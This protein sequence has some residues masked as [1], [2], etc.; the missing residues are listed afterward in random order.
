MDIKILSNV[1][2]KL[3]N[4]KEISFQ[5]I[6]S[7]KTPSKEELKVILCKTLNLSPSTTVIVNVSQV[8]GVM[9]SSVLAHSYAHEKDMV[10]E[11]KHFAK[12]AEKKAGKGEEKKEPE[13]KKEEKKEEAKHEKEEKKE[14]HHEKKEENKEPEKKE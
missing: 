5:V 6:Y 1:D 4:R 2:N 12:R 13:A 8:F 3:L 14:A 7:G 11:P 9:N 10:V